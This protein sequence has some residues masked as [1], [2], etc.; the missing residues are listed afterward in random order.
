M[1]C[2]P[3]AAKQSNRGG[4]DINV[5][6]LSEFAADI[7]LSLSLFIDAIPNQVLLQSKLFWFVV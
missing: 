4:E 7:T 5:V 3:L 1:T 2:L 6:Y